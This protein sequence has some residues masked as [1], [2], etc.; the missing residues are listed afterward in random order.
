MN[1][2]IRGINAL[3]VSLGLCCLVLMGCGSSSSSDSAAPAASVVVVDCAMV[4]SAETVTV[5]FGMTTFSPSS[6]TISVNDV[7][8]WYNASALNHTVTSGI[9]TGGTTT[10][11]TPDGKFDEALAPNG[12]TVCLQF[13]TAGTYNY[14]CTPHYAMGMTGVVTVQ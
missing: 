2:K 8:Q 6:V 14:Y 11:A 7:V 3:V 12:T 13:T 4:T 1:A 5:P 10:T 9:V